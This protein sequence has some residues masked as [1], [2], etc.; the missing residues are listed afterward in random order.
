MHRAPT[1]IL[2]R[3]YWKYY[4]KIAAL[5]P[6]TQLAPQSAGR[7]KST[8]PNLTP[9]STGTL[10]HIYT[11]FARDDHRSSIMTFRQS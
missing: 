10:H 7:E 4:T 11:L 1:I 2:T 8:I 9:L 3:L 6:D 5:R